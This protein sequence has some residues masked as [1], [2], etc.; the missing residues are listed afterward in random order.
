MAG[1]RARVAL[2]ALLLHS[3][4]PAGG[5]SVEAPL[6][7]APSE[8]PS[9]ANEAGQC[10]APGGDNALL[11]REGVLRRVRNP[12]SSGHLS[13]RRSPATSNLTIVWDPKSERH[14]PL[15]H[16]TLVAGACRRLGGDSNGNISME[17]VRDDLAAN[18]TVISAFWKALH[19]PKDTVT[20]ADL[21]SA[22][23]RWVVK[24]G[25][26]LPDYSD[27]G[28]Y[29]LRGKSSCSVDV[30]PKRLLETIMP[31]AGV[32]TREPP[33]EGA[34]VVP[35]EEDENGDGQAHNEER[36]VARD[37]DIEKGQAGLVQR[38]I[39][40][41]GNGGV[42]MQRRRA[43]ASA[44]SAAAAGAAAAMA[45]EH[46]HHIKGFC[47]YSFWQ[48]AERLANMFRFYPARGVDMSIAMG[49][50]S[51][52]H[53][54]HRGRHRGGR[55]GGEDGAK[56]DERPE[57]AA[58]GE[59]DAHVYDTVDAQVES[60]IAA[61]TVQAK[62]WMSAVLSEMARNGTLPFRSTWFGGPG[63]LT[64][65]EVRERILLT[66]NFI[67]RELID[68]IHFV[69]PADLAVDT[70]CGGQTIA[71][72]WKWVSNEEGYYE[73]AGPICQDGADPTLNHCG[74]DMQGRYFVYLCNLWWTGINTNSRISTLVHE[75]SHHAGPRDVTYSRSYMKELPQ[76]DQLHNAANFQ[77]FAQDVAQTAWGCPDAEVVVGLPF[78]CTPSPCTCRAF[79]DMCEDPTFGL[80]IK[81]MC[82]A[83]CGLCDAPEVATTTTGLGG[84]SIDPE[85]TTTTAA[86]TTT[87]TTTGGDVVVVETATG[88]C[89]QPEGDVQIT[90]ENTIFIGACT[91]F[92]V[93]G[94]CNDPAVSTQCPVSCEVC[95]PDG[96]GDDPTFSIMTS[97]G[98]LT[99]PDWKVYDCW[100]E[101][102]VHCPSAC[103]VGPC[104]V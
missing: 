49:N 11:Q 30:H 2:L 21:C 84:E 28:C 67:E 63:N 99:C 93:N 17:E 81:H 26:V 74:V 29:T 54:H 80:Q 70:S 58:F 55:G 95:V 83:T 4:S 37:L 71:Y 32:K 36:E 14:L 69:Y 19:L 66:M 102:K 72:V 104:G 52:H 61:T 12:E 23:T 8:C 68:G 73:T 85:V 44:S 98:I 103:S 94:K 39:V 50:H 90:I 22:L 75:A 47:P 53:G 10:S 1:A 56:H 20:C 82:P 15:C 33:D 40:L 89:C 16:P 9:G 42:R 18:K 86:T 60:E 78:T 51:G 5:A 48:I 96:C 24:I 97:V 88:G 65:Q 91:A 76:R 64:T 92:A 43:S 38:S 46:H 57:P 79:Q 25:G 6:R 59:V 62:A 100:E 35:D 27:A 77:Y 31:G 34:S 41:D 101:V 13:T 87:A 3:S 7:A 45:W